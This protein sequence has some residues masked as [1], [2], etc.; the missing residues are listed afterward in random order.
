M[1]ITKRVPL[2]TVV[3]IGAALMSSS[4]AAAPAQ[5]AQE[6]VSATAAGCV[7]YRPGLTSTR[8]SGSPTCGFWYAVQFYEARIGGGY[9]GPVNGVMGVNSWKGVQRYL[10]NNGAALAVDGA[11][12][13][14]TYRAMQNKIN[15]FGSNVPRVTVDGI[16]GPA[17]YRSWAAML[18]IEST[19]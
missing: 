17:T 15:Q 6:S 7:E 11:P 14:A 12:G 13:P 2:I 5:A 9:T 3:A 4:I 16:V 1:R 19:Y 10:N 18:L 8:A